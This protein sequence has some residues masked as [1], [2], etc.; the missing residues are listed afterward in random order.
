MGPWRTGREEV[1]SLAGRVGSLEGGSGGVRKDPGLD[2]RR[3]GQ[4][5]KN[6]KK[7]SVKRG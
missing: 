5:G 6:G 4:M 7:K 1:W 3:G 2:G